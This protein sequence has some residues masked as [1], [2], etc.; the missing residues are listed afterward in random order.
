VRYAAPD[1]SEHLRFRQAGKE[2]GVKIGIIG[3]GNVGG[4]LGRLWAQQG[5]EV[6]YGVRQPDG[7]KARAVLEASGSH[8]RAAGLADPAAFGEVVVIAVP[9]GA[10]SETLSGIGDVAGKVVIDCVNHVVPPGQAAMV[11]EEIARRLPGARVVKAFN[12]TG[13]NI[14]ADTRFGDMH[15]DTY[16]A[17]DDAQAKAVVADLARA[18]G[19]EVVDVGP[20]ANAALVEG[21]ARLWIELAYRQGMGREIAFKLLH[22]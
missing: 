17:G 10:L 15:A 4:T 2:E 19:F 13:S 5:H 22:R 18:I 3:A 16:I 21:L 7:E 20:L 9:W 12:T 11:A 8:A 1:G 6:V 14:M